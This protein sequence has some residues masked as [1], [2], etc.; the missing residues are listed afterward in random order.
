MTVTEYCGEM[1]E[2][3]SKYHESENY[4]KTKPVAREP[5]TFFQSK[6]ID[7]FSNF[8]K[9]PVVDHCCKNGYMTKYSFIYNQFSLMATLL[10]WY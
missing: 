9:K 6:S 7:I 1:P 8:S 2:K 4:S 3:L 5:D 10:D